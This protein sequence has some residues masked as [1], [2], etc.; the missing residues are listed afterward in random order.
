MKQNEAPRFLRK[1]LNGITDSY[2]KFMAKELLLDFAT[3]VL[4]V[5]DS[6]YNEHEISVLPRIGY[7]FPNGFNTDFGEQRFKI[8]EALFN[9][10]FLKGVHANAMLDVVHLVTS[11]INMCDAELRSVK[12]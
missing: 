6:T 4:Q 2:K 9:P 8:P 3:H 7:E 11:S 12:K 10:A 1:D 5:S